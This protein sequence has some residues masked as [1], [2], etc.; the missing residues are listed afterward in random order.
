[1]HVEAETEGLELSVVIPVSDEE[2]ILE[3]N[4]N[5]IKEYLRSLHHSFE[6]VLVENG[7]R[8]NTR[9]M[10][11]ELTRDDPALKALY[12]PVRD[13]GLALKKGFECSQGEYVIWYPIDLA[14][15]LEYIPRSL[16]LIKEYQMVVGSKD[17]PDSHVRR[18]IMRNIFSKTYNR[19]VNLLFGLGLGD[20]QCVKTFQKKTLD[21]I[22]PKTKSRGIVF[23]VELLYRAKQM[24]VSVL[25]VPVNV[26]DTR[27]SSGMISL[28][29]FINTFRD[30]IL[31]R[32]R[33]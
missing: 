4:L 19:M 14:V 7:S 33:I 9:S 2:R 17:H 32:G 28:V 25:E 27:K 8:D 6:I 26:E 18:P 10:L 21:E 1:M 16:K 13:V 23:E 24:G 5:S 30:L 15:D 31:L 20:T 11:E 12:L 22:L 29:F 3:G